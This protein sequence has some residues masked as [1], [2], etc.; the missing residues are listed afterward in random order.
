MQVPSQNCY[1]VFQ[2]TC[3]Q[4]PEESC[5]DRDEPTERQ[6]LSTEVLKRK[7]DASI[8]ALWEESAN[9]RKKLAERVELKVLEL[10]SHQEKRVGN[11]EA[12]LQELSQSV[13]NYEKLRQQDQDAISCIRGEAA[14]IA[15]STLPL[16]TVDFNEEPAAQVYSAVG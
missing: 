6:Q 1:Q 11:L 3:T 10:Q 8:A 14:T 7:L 15:S 16:A 2:E 4:A 13:G 12:R 9:M 5:E